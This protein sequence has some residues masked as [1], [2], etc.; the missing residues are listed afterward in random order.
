[1]DQVHFP[2]VS[3]GFGGRPRGLRW[4]LAGLVLRSVDKNGVTI[5]PSRSIGTQKSVS[6]LRRRDDGTSAMTPAG[7]T[8]SLFAST[9]SRN[10]SHRRLPI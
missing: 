8:L 5:S 9:L 6:D 1:M 2:N 7:S 4:R 3:V 10:A